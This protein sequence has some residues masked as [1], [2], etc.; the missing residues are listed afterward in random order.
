MCPSKVEGVGYRRDI[1][2]DRISVNGVATCL[3]YHL[4]SLDAVFRG[5][6]STHD[7]HPPSPAVLVRL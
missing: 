2:I 4:R 6:R 5:A 3:P 1:V 7:R